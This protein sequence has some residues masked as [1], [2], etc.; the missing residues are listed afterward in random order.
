MGALAQFKAIAISPGIAGLSKFRRSRQHDMADHFAAA[1]QKLVWIG[2][3]G[4][5]EEKQTHP[6]RGEPM[7]K[8]GS[9]PR[10][11]RPNAI[12]SAL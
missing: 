6:S 1:L 10:T 11:E 7:E 8:A 9:D 12:T 2:Q 4:A 3:A 5:L